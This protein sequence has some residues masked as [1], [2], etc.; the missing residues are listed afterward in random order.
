VIGAEWRKISPLHQIRPEMPP[1]LIF[2]GDK[3]S[4]APFP[5]LTAFCQKMSESKNVCE[6]VLETGGVHGHINN[7][8]KLFDNAANQTITFLSKQQ[9]G[10]TSGEDTLVGVNYFAGWWKE[11]PNKWHGQGWNINQP[12][13]RPKFPGRVPLLGEYNTQATMDLEIEAA[14]SHGVDFFA[15]LYY[16]PQPGARQAKHAPMLNRGLETFLASPNAD[17]MK[18]CIEYCNAPDFSARNE[19][20]W[21]DC[22]KVWVAAMKHPSYLRVDGRLVFKV[23]GISQFLKTHNHDYKL[24]RKRLDALRNAVRGAGLGEMII[25]VGVAGQT[26]PLGRGWP[27][28][29]LFDFTAT[30]MCVPDIKTQETEYPYATLAQQARTTLK[31]RVADPIPWM[32]YLAAGWNPR[33]WTYPKAPPHYQRF[34]KFPT[35]KEFTD[36][37]KA[38]KEA[39]EKHPSLGLPKRDGTRRKI[40]TIYAWNE[41]GEGGIVAP[42]KGRG[43]MMLD[44][45]KHVFGGDNR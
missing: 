16:F 21:S 15:I 44:S 40:F 28:A 11:L 34:F 30:Y 22:V 17:K 31:N 29:E 14:S 32:P 45:I 26:P 19:K 27:P 35:G 10:T 18:F 4:V 41:F 12:D 43:T 20:E 2:H 6:L 36:E 25:G 23:H 13:W 3:D 42:T 1:T 37:L 24:C 5:T 39:L 33:P 38:M 7:D 9:L 8:M